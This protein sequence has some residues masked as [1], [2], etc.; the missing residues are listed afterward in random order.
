LPFLLSLTTF[1]EPCTIGN[2]TSREDSYLLIERYC[3][4]VC[5]LQFGQYA[6]FP[7]L[8]HGIFTRVGGYS[9]PPYQS[10]NTSGSLKGGDDLTHVIQN[11]QRILQALDLQDTPCATLWNVHGAD[12]AVFERSAPWRTDWAHRSYYDVP[13]GAAYI[14][15]ADALL[16]QER[17]VAL[18]LSFG[19]CTPIALYD[20]VRQAIGIA[21]GGWRG[22]ARGVVLAA[23]EAMRERF[24]SHPQDIYAGLGPTIGPC[25]YEVSE[26]VRDLF[27][28]KAQFDDMPTRAHYRA[29]VRE[30]A[31]FSTMQFPERTSLRLD[32]E[33]TT[34]HQ[35]LLAGIEPEH[36]ETAALCTSCHKD[37]FFSHRAE[38]GKTGRFPLV[39][40]LRTRIEIGAVR[41]RSQ[42][43]RN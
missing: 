38:Q 22:T 11:R 35:L 43:K 3:G 25:C 39:M 12:V 26:Q 1:K 27:M 19:D 32:L 13:W 14:R 10:L 31:V 33:T 36:I 9:A 7:E 28:G 41:A 30:S 37:R 29:L 2:D 23:L 6:R 5:Y 18:A 8:V 34:R 21:H 20:P 24:G 42:N 17:G 16:T 40:S 15:K 4:E